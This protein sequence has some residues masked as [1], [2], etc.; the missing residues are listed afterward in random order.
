M[1]CCTGRALAERLQL[2]EDVRHALAGVGSGRAGEADDVRDRGVAYDDARDLVFDF[3]HRRSLACYQAQLVWGQKP[4][5]L[6]T[7]LSACIEL[8]F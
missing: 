3:G 8:S 4:V 7:G 6:R 5:L 2:D 1:T